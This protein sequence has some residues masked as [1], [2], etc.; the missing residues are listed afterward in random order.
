M[1]FIGITFILYYIKLS[2]GNGFWNNIR[3]SDENCY[4]A[5]V[6]LEKVSKKLNKA[7]MDLLFLYNCRD[8]DLHPKFTRWKNFKTLDDKTRKKSYQK[9]LNDEI[10][11][12]HQLIKKLSTLYEMK[13][14][15]FSNETTWMKRF[16]IKN[17]IDGIIKADSIKIA[18][19]HKKKLTNLNKEKM[20]RD[21]LT[22][23]PNQCIINLTGTLLNEE[24]YNALQF[25]LKYG[26]ATLPKENDLIASA[27][28]FWEQLERNNLLSGDFNKIQR[29][30]N[31][32][33]GL[34]FNFL[35]F[36]DRRIQ[37]DNKRIKIV[38]ELCE[39]FV[40]LRPDKGG[41]IVLMNR[42]D[43]NNK[44][45]FLFSDKKKFKVL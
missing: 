4:N 45:E 41:G 38:K 37:T 18:Q 2:D 13:N 14:E 32:L 26:V 35:N 42:T 6:A 20:K 27:E 7:K 44:I 29:A 8:E 28:S 30:K 31:C 24:Q 12:K 23:N 33:R 17:A 22:N 21:G 43:Y 10:K 40:I 16:I 5:A 19:R 9:V 15:S 36:Q 25:G 3:M 34:V 11:N 39:N 1:K